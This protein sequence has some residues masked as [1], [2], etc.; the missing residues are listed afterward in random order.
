[1]E[2]AYVIPVAAC[3]LAGGWMYVQGWATLGQVTAVTLYAQALIDP[4][5]RLISWLDEIAVGATSLARIIGVAG[6][7]PDRVATGAS[8]DDERISASDVRFSYSRGRDVLHGVSLALRP[9]ERIAV[10]GPSGAGK[11]TMGR[12]LAGIHPPRTGQVDVGGVPLVDLELDELRGHVALVTQEH[13]IFVGT[14]RDN[15]RLAQTD[16]SDQELRRAL[17]AVD[18]LDWAEALPDGLDTVLGT[19]G[20]Q[21]SPPQAQQIA[22]ARLVLSDPHTL[23]LDEA[24]SLL[25]PRAARHLERSLSAVLHGRT[26]VAIAHRLHTAHDADR[27]VVME[28]GQVSEIGTHD[29]LV[30]ADGPYAA[31]W[32]SWHAKPAVLR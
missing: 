27:V 14:V 18:A 16:A 31:L 29:E 20:H 23:V 4:V 21:L 2:M 8:T 28:D 17:A 7:P 25:D 22:L 1:V 6:V 12:L 13:H 24:T 32:E 3:V 26:V 10:V 11:S 30:D 15:L 5:D 9:G 19:D